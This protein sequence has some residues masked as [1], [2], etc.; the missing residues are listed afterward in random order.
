MTTE[1]DLYSDNMEHELQV[2]K[3]FLTQELA[4]IDAAL[5]AYQSA[6]VKDGYA[7]EG[8]EL[9]E[10]EAKDAL[11]KLL[12]YARGKGRESVTLGEAVRVMR[13]FRVYTHKN[14]GH[15]PLSEVKGRGG[16][17]LALLRIIQSPAN[18][19]LFELDNSSFKTEDWKLALVKPKRKP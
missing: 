16:M 11:V 15:K 17:R 4:R 2:R 5:R 12:E 14:S 7:W 9:D 1:K 3:R 6:S 13:N 10:T 19:A 8:L 18:K